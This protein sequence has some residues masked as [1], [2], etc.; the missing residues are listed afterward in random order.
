VVHVQWS[1]A[2]PLDGAWVR[3]LRRSGVG[4]VYSAHNVVPHESRPWHPAFHKWLHGAAGRVIVHSRSTRD[5][6]VRLGGA[7]EGAVRV[8]P[9]AADDPSTVAGRE[10][11][12]GVLDPPV[13]P[14]V[15]LALFFGHVRPYK[16]LDLL[17]DAAPSL[18]ARMPAAKILVCGPVLGG[19]QG[20]R[21]LR[22]DIIARGVSDIV[23][24]RPGYATSR[25]ARACLSAADVVVLPY[26][27]VSDSAVLAAARGHGRAVVATDVGSL[28][29]ALEDG[30]GL[31]VPPGDP[32]RLAEAMTEV[33]ERP[34]TRE[35]LEAESR[36]AA[37]SWTWS[38]AAEATLD[39]YRE[40]VAEATR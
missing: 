16:G 3:A 29:E 33:L 18:R 21:R 9:M 14:A 17:L 10:E 22:D 30:G 39:V 13:G 25:T 31:V 28:A 2:P 37:R 36:Q 38:D 6:L 20:V 24:L 11:A 32:E 35:R 26:R 19:E 1:L 5:E 12:R 27:A 7:P 8:V 40:V 23:D 4:T 34:G 15:P